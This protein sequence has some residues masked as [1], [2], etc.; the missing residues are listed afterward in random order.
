MFE[1]QPSPYLVPR[2]A[3][4]ILRTFGVSESEPESNYIRNRGG[5]LQDQDHRLQIHP[6]VLFLGISEKATFFTAKR[7]PDGSKKEGF[8]C[9]APQADFFC[10]D[11]APLFSGFSSFP[12]EMSQKGHF[13]HEN[14]V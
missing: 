13:F 8:A 11:I 10:G 2:T 5:I 7:L 3:R 9:L 14:R 12:P 4:N 1:V 6:P